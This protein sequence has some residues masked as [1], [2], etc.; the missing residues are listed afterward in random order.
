MLIPVI[1]IPVLLTAAVIGAVMLWP[2]PPSRGD[3]SFGSAFSALLHVGVGVIAIL[4][5]WLI[6]FAIT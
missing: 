2:L 6:Y 1:M 4:T 3:Y 5:V